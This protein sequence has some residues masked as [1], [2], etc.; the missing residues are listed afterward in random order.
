MKLTVTGAPGG[1]MRINLFEGSRRIGMLFGALWVVGCTV[2]AFTGGPSAIGHDQAALQG[3][4]KTVLA[5]LFGGLAFGWVFM[6]V[7]GW[8]VRGFLGVPRGA[9]ERPPE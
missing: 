9:D 7:T 1:R 2:F 5:V 8:V 4:V 6:A 3:H